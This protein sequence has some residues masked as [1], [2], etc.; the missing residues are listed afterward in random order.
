M[1]SEHDLPPQTRIGPWGRHATRSVY[2]N[3]WIHLREDAVIRPDGNPGVYG[4]VE[5][6]HIAV[7]VVAVDDSNQIVLVG[8]HRYPLNYYSWEIPEGGCHKESDSPEQA[9]A[10]EL[11]EE[12]GLEAKRW[13]YLGCLALSNSVSD[14]V[15]HLFLARDLSHGP[16]APEPTEILQ[17]KWISL[18]EA[19]RQVLEG[20]ITESISIA[21]LLRARHF[22][23][24]E[25]SGLPKTEY[26]REV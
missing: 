6:S 2:R 16:A 21:G 12:T 17:V 26:R 1:A 3:P 25:K 15:A 24:R 18:K 22:L 10:R 4:V 13:D 14:E 9:A 19:C 8:Q 20:K 5:F 11:R 23:E 7:G